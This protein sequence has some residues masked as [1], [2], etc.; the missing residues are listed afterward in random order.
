M[1]ACIIMSEVNAQEARV[2]QVTLRGVDAAMRG[3]LVAEA[4][5]RG[6]SLNRTL[7]ALVREA[8]GLDGGRE[9]GRRRTF[10]DLDHLA[11][12]W[13][14]AETKRILKEAAR[15]RCVDAEIWR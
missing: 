7:L 12:T 1:N 13:D 4:R 11:G 2:A 3:A 15:H 10:D 6:L 5:R 14:A 8:V 9:A